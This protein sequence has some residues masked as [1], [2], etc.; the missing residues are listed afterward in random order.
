MTADDVSVKPRTAQVGQMPLSHS[1]SF[2]A[3]T[4]LLQDNLHQPCI[5][6]QEDSGN[7]HPIPYQD[8]AYPR[9][10]IGRSAALEA[11]AKA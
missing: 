5:H 4:I 6:E 3:L 7:V 1:R 9:D 2:P 11:E 8:G 10:G